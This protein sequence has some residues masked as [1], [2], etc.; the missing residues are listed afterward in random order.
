MGK[1]AE[2]YTKWGPAERYIQHT[3]GFKLD[4]SGSFKSI[5]GDNVRL[6]DPELVPKKLYRYRSSNSRYIRKSVFKV[7]FDTATFWPLK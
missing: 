1:P 4:S 3:N 2:R 5:F 7:C 6:K